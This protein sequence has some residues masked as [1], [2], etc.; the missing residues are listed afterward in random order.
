MPGLE[1]DPERAYIN[2]EHSGSIVEIDYADGLR[3]ARELDPGL[4]ARLI[5]ETGR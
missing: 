4:P 1:I 2:D 5:V 3:T